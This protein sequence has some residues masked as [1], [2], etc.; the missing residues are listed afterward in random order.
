MR[1]ENLLRSIDDA[2][3]VGNPDVEITGITYDSRKT[4]PGSLFVAIQGLTTDG[5]RF[6]VDALNAGAACVVLQKNEADNESF[7]Q[8]NAVKVIVKDSRKALA[9][10]SGVF[11]NFPAKKLRLIGVTGTNGK[12]TSTYLIKSILES[13]G[14]KVGLI[15]TIENKVGGESIPAERTTPESLDIN[16]MLHKMVEAGATSAVMEVSSHALALDRVHGFDFDIAVFS[17]LTHDHLDFHKTIDEYLRAKKS[18]FD[19]LRKSDA[20]AIYNLDDRFGSRMIEDCRARK[21]AY[22][23]NPGVDIRAE[24]IALSIERA[25]FEIVHNG[26]RFGV[27]SNLI[28]KFNVYNILASASAGI[29]LGIETDIIKA[30]IE[31][32][33]TVRGRFEQMYLPNGAVVVI[34]YSH[35][36]DSLKKCLETI[37]D[38]LLLAEGS[39]KM[40]KIITVFGCG[41]DRDRTKRPKMGRIATEL[42]DVTIVTSD[43]PRS[44]DPE[45]IIDEIIVGVNREAEVIRE[46]DRREAIIKGLRIVQRGDVLLLAGKGHEDYQVIGGRKFHFDEREIV[47][48][49]TRSQK[50]P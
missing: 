13:A 34:D 2:S 27:S 24:N 10:L 1:L 30:G 3:V 33:K 4:S 20:K 41:G 26:K 39:R 38:V 36:P 12:T 43:N 42:S 14:E 8:R 22:G 19:G 29:A 47:E 23:L 48:E 37:R 5:H 49:L 16:W 11:Y 25:Q 9:K 21:Y 15:G 28:G 50:R 46:S 7:L 17:N 31:N 44:E 32:V 40:A 45:K 35:T 6:I 18:L